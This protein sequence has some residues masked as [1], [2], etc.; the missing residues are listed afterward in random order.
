MGLLRGI[1]GSGNGGL[2]QND[3]L[4]EDSGDVPDIQAAEHTPLP[5]SEV[6]EP[7]AHAEVDNF[8]DTDSISSHSVSNAVT[9]YLNRNDSVEESAASMIDNPSESMAQLQLLKS[10]LLV[11][12]KEEVFEEERVDDAAQKPMKLKM[13]LAQAYMR[14]VKEERGGT[15]HSLT[16]NSVTSNKL[17]A[18][19]AAHL[20]LQEGKNGHKL[21][22][23][24]D[25]ATPLGPLEQRLSSAEERGAGRQ[26][27]S[28]RLQHQQE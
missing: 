14:E 25:Q 8:S 28:V 1:K 23:R 13:K 11:Q 6:P 2:G 7:S 22:H 21:A 12:P 17:Q 24:H 4:Y 26:L 18:R 20:K 15:S 19:S 27:F 5:L 10:G 3:A 9:K 16:N